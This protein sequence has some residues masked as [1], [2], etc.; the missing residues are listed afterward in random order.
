MKKRKDYTLPLV[1]VM[2]VT[3]GNILAASPGITG[4]GD[5]FEWET[6]SDKEND[7]HAALRLYFSED[8]DDGDDSWIK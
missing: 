1:T 8:S 6:Q 4:T 5:D 2:N 7:E 3:T